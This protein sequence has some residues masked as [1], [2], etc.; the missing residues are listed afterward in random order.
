MVREEPNRGSRQ[1]DTLVVTHAAG[2]DTRDE[3]SFTVGQ[4]ENDV[5]HLA[6]QVLEESRAP[7]FGGDTPPS[8]ENGGPDLR[9]SRQDAAQ[10]DAEGSAR[11]IGRDPSEVPPAAPASSEARRQELSPGP[12]IEAGP[13]TLNA[14]SASRI[15]G[16]APEKRSLEGDPG[17]AHP[18]FSRPTARSTQSAGS[19]VEQGDWPF[20]AAA[21]DHGVPHRPVTISGWRA[22]A[23]D[24]TRAAE[25]TTT[26]APFDRSAQ[27]S[28]EADLAA[29]G[30]RREATADHAMRSSFPVG[31]P[32]L[33][34][35]GALPDRADKAPEILNSQV[36][37]P[38]TPYATFS[39]AT[40]VVSPPLTRPDGS[41][42]ARAVD[43]P[44]RSGGLD[45]RND[46]QAFQD[47]TRA[48]EA[49][50]SPRTGAPHGQEAR[51]AELA[52]S[53]AVQIAQHAQPG[54]GSVVELQLSP[55]ELGSVKFLMSLSESGL[56][57]VVQADRPETQELMRRH[58][59]QL[60]AHFLSLGFGET[61]ISFGGGQSD[62]PSGHDRD[63][64]AVATPSVD[65]EGGQFRETR[66]P[67][68]IGIDIRI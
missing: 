53:I 43:M 33:S 3:P 14:S 37:N 15:P 32:D 1:P 55:E 28:P 16:E 47:Q 48:I 24:R 9:S 7:A 5:A 59:D 27:V 58:L 34:R 51:Q 46:L 42:D 13:A 6:P 30:I 20:M 56:N 63:A 61:S 2:L 62:A 65:D 18:S 39:V 38:Q 68:G 25:E 4:R 50:P 57:I 40:G 21:F 67:T 35:Y 31:Q 23:A 60:Q 10:Q 12:S 66:A 54:G 36:K 44:P 64:D 22:P 29:T 17:S 26:P 8:P 52:R 49:T 41:G 45:Q 19:P 11:N